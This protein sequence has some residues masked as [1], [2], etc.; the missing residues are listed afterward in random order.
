V[1]NRRPGGVF[2]KDTG[3]AGKENAFLGEAI[4]GRRRGCLSRGVAREKG[5]DKVRARN[6]PTSLGQSRTRRGEEG[7]R[8]AQTSLTEKKGDHGGNPLRGKMRA[9]AKEEGRAICPV[10]D[11]DSVVSW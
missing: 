9:T 1:P 3:E 10:Q 5:G 7:E 2:Q 4:G 8:R 6:S 11:P